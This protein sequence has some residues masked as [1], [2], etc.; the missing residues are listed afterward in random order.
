MNIKDIQNNTIIICENNYKDNILK[1]FGEEHLFLNVKFFTKKE[2]L[3]EYLFSYNE[4]ILYYVVEKYDLKVEIAKMYLDN[5]IYIEDKEYKNNKLKFLADLKKE[6]K[7]NNLLIYNNDFKQYIKKYQI[8]VV[9][10]PYLEKIERDIF[11]S[12]N[13]KILE[14]NG[15]KTIEYVYEFN[16]MEEEV[17]FVCKRVAKLIEKG[18]PLHKIKLMGV[19]EEYYNDLNRIFTFYNIPINIPKP[20]SLYNNEITK[21]F[22]DNLEY[23]VKNAIDKIKNLNSDIVNKIIN[24]CNK[25]NFVENNKYFK[26][27]ITYEFKKTK[28]NNFKLKNYIDII[29]VF[30]YVKDDYVFLMNFNAGIIPKSIK[31]ED[32]ITDNIKD[33]ASLDLVVDINK[34]YKENTIKRLKSINNLVITYK[35]KDYKKEYYPS[36]LVSELNLEIKHEDNN[37]KESYSTVLDK[38]NL[39]KLEFLQEKYGT[40]SN[41]YYIY[42]NNFKDFPYNTFDNT[43]KGIDNLLLKDFLKN[44]LTLSYSSLN[45][46]NKCAFRYYINNILR[47]DK[48]EETF[49]AFIGS[50][51]H[52]VLEKCF[53]EN[54]NVK[55]EIN[56]YIKESGKCLTKKEE[57]FIDIIREDIEF[58]IN[59]LNKQKELITLD[60]SLYEKDI[61]INKDRDME[62]KF[63]GF[64][65]KI[66]YKEEN[67]KTLVAI[68]DY[69]TGHMDTNLKYVPYGLHMQLPIYLYLV[70]NANLFKNPKFVGFY[71]QNI[72]DKSIIADKNSSYEDK[73]L[74]NL[75]LIGYSNY[76]IHSLA[77]LDSSYENS[78]LIKGLKVKNNGDFYATSKVLRDKEIDNLIN[79]TE[80]NVDEVIDKILVG[81]FK[82]NP[83]KIGFDKDIG[84]EYCRFKDLCFKKEQD[85]VILDDIEDLSFLRGEEDA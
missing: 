32:Y 18:V 73:R 84:C 16:T 36:S 68:I 17:N 83:K 78:K 27:L 72:L 20:N 11:K 69:K 64:V 26:E 66:L 49:E 21:I 22:L 4:K 54:L 53:S 67:D 71:I 9:G 81:D 23:G 43:Y 65:D 42:K 56:N 10:Y 79:V 29:N 25:Y 15:T 33:E 60:K 13:T 80:K 46:Y 51:F 35:L 85:Y 44:K 40:T 6:L 59:A 19:T 2:F 48:Y 3:K 39:A 70:K 14:D 55:E 12:L 31:D 75:K 37:I 38:I 76:D 63:I 1:S 28:I 41:E 58:V 30:D 74:D 82:I 52:D 57:F 45:N 47:L 61:V 8:I 50:I 34:Y 7:E 24:I 62:V 5:L 77:S